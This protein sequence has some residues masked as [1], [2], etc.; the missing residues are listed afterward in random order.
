MARTDV[1]QVIERVRRQLNSTVRLE[2][3]VLGSSLTTTTNP[4]TLSY[5]LPN[6]LRAGA[7]LAVGTELMRVISVDT[8]AKEATVIRG[9]MDS[10]PEA[11]AS[12]DEV[13]IN[14]RF[15][16]FDIF[17]AMLSEIDSWSPDIFTISDYA[18]TLSGGVTQGIELP[19][20]MIDA[21]GVIDVRRNYTED[22]SSVW[23]AMGFTLHRGRSASL[24]PTE[25]SGL[26]VRLTDNLGYAKA[27]GNVTIRVAM[28][29]TSES[30]TEATDLDD[31]LVTRG[32]LEVIELGIK[33]RLMADDEV[34]RSAR[35]HQDEPRRAEEVQGGQ[36]LTLGQTF[37]QR[38][39]K[40]RAQEV[41]RLR[42]I[43]PFQQF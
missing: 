38:Y 6:S 28:P 17:D 39:E 43:Y 36:A 9:Y 37:L 27:D 31:I 13:Q 5:D 12:G 42:T 41:R 10:D 15:T 35:G 24:T 32:L 11:H 18:T 8:G 23:P 30:I 26:F 34:G 7:V 2:V 20:S 1:T 21:L 14:P 4:V 3:N 40:R 29:Y 25:G 19:S 16:R 33:A 22:D